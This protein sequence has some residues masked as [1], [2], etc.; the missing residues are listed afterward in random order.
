MTRLQLYYYVLIKAQVTTYW[1]KINHS[2]NNVINIVRYNHL[3]R[4]KVMPNIG[5][6]SYR[7][8]VSLNSMK[9]RLNAQSVQDIC[10]AGYT[11]LFVHYKHQDI[12]TINLIF[13]KH[14][15]LLFKF[16]QST[17]NQYKSTNLA[18]KQKD[19]KPLTTKNSKNKIQPKTQT[20]FVFNTQ[21]YIAL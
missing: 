8:D 14:L 13:S 7:T 10:T 6:N 3:S 5:Y 4:N 18:Y 17:S 12:C 1:C 11:V 19:L 20:R 15:I 2:H 16:N 21:R 9:S